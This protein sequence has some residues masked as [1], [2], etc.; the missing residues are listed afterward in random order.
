M[1]TQI[2]LETLLKR[3]VHEWKEENSNNLDALFGIVEE[4]LKEPTQPTKLV[5]NTTNKPPRRE[6]EYVIPGSKKKIRPVVQASADDLSG[7]GYEE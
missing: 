5:P 7:G 6:G 2:P 4:M 3:M 1:Q